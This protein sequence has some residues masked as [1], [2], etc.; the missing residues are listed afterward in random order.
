M[1]G[2]LATEFQR[3]HGMTFDDMQLSMEDIVT[4][5]GR[6][7]IAVSSNMELNVDIQGVKRRLKN[8]AWQKCARW[9]AGSGSQMLQRC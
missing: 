4:S 9:C 1:I 5:F 2:Q 7:E 6:H 3:V 8:G